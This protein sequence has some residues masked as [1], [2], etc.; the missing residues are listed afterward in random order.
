MKGVVLARNA[1][2]VAI[3]VKAGGKSGVFVKTRE[4]DITKLEDLENLKSQ[5]YARFDGKSRILTH[6]TNEL[7]VVP[8]KKNN[9]ENQIVADWIRHYRW[10]RH[11]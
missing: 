2:Y 1:Q 10:E 8:P 3:D 11:D 5:M 6:S 4:N 9:F 7:E